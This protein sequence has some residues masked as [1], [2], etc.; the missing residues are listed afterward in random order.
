[1]SWAYALE[2]NVFDQMTIRCFVADLLAAARDMTSDQELIDSNAPY[3]SLFY[4]GFYIYSDDMNQLLTGVSE[5]R[6]DDRLF[7]IL[8]FP[9]N[10]P[11]S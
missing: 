11:C 8:L 2:L 3:N 4:I 1:M 6:I 5:F 9:R 10:T 7:A